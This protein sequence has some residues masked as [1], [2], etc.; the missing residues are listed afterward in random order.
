MSTKSKNSWGRFEQVDREERYRILWA[1][2]G[3]G[4]SGKTHFGLTAPEPIAVHLFDP[5][6]LEGLVRQDAFKDKDIRVIQYD[7]EPGKLSEADRP[8]AAKD[9]LDRF[10]EDYATALGIART[11][12]WD[13]EDYVWEML[14][15]AKLE[16]VSGAPATYYELNS[17]YRS[18]L[19][20][21][22]HSGV[23]LG[24][25]R[26][27]REIWGQRPKANG[28]L[29]P[30]ATGKYE[31]R[32]MKEVPELVQV[33]LDHRWDNEQRQFVVTIGPDIDGFQ[34]CRVGNAVELLGTEHPGLDFETLAM[35]L[36]PETVDMPDVWK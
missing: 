6:G 19:A 20:D 22:A 28:G 16:A 7:F 27:M 2:Q 1:S 24:L 31:A 21:A 29:Q 32:G 4:G 5:D 14:R 12:L 33:Y 3:P 18:W 9:A 23:N 30:F 36:Y 13:K 34:K 17:K 35:M 8:A 26:G 11:V 15:Y 10:E 25:I